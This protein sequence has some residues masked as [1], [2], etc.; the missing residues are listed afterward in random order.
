[1]K[2]FSLKYSLL[3]AITISFIN[4]N[5]P[6]FANAQQIKVTAIQKNLKTLENS[7]DGRIGIY[8]IDMNNNK[9]I[10]YRSKERFP[11]QSTFKLIGVSAILKKSMTT[12]N[13]LQQ[14]ITYKKQDL[15]FWSPIT[16]KYLTKGMTISQLS[17]ATM[18]YSDNTAINL[19]MKKLGG[20]KTVTAFAHS[21]GDNMFRVEHWEPKL[22]SNP[23]D[24]DDTS[25][26]EAMEKS[27]Q[28]LAFG[29][30]LEPPLRA[31]LISWMKGNTTGDTRIRA[32]VPK[33]WV[34][35]DKTG[36][37]P[38]NNYGIVNDIGIIWPPKCSAPI[39]VVIYTVGNQKNTNSNKEVVA[40][41]TR[42][43]LKTFAKAG[44]CIRLKSFR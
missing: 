22:N 4:V 6:V 13:L 25:T 18:M 38:S 21:I 36:S 42:S 39:V 27:L 31:Q 7:F 15:V 35:A 20:P 43:L 32:G 14:K 28:K 40:S 24:F 2:L 10:E 11:I 5:V 44:Q 33:G 41:A 16:K 34:V 23:R 8:A 1:M 29:N 19:L 37:S 3:L 12:P 9:H 26:P 30:V 17:A